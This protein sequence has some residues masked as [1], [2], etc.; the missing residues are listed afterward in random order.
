MDKRVLYGI[1]CLVVVASIMM[2][3]NM[4]HTI[5]E[6]SLAVVV[7]GTNAEFKPFSF[8]E[9]GTITGFDI[10]V[11][12]EVFNRLGKKVTVKDMPFDVLIPEVQLGNVH[13]IAGGITPTDER[14]KRIQFT[15]PHLTT[16]MLAVVSL[17]DVHLSADQ[18]NGKTVVVN[19]GYTAD[20]YMSERKDVKLIR[21]SSNSVSDGI[22]ALQSGRAD[23]FVTAIH[24]LT[25]YFEKYG[26]GSLSVMPI[27]GTQESSAF[28]VS[29]HHK[30]LQGQMQK[31]LDTMEHDGTLNALKKKWNVE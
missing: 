24:P 3:R 17:N 25:P 9:N 31:V 1:C 20:S 19:E 26:T 11:V 10:D 16:D 21:L 4:R 15:N 12:T 22:L 2:W 29:N 7:I 18:L 13:V 8:I 5:T 30:E 27:N 14:K 6:P 23:A 28:A